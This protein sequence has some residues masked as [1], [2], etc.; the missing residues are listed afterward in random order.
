MTIKLGVLVSG[1]GSNLQAIVDAVEGGTLDAQVAVVL[2]SRPGVFALERAAAA[3]IET[4]A[5][6]PSDY[7]DPSVADSRITRELRARGVDYVVMAGYMRMLGPQVLDAFPDRV[8]NLHPALLP[9]F[10]GAHAIADAFSAGVKVT[11]VTVH[12]ANEVYDEGPIV[13]QEP[14]RVFEGDSLE[15]LEARIHEVEH[16]MYPEVLQLIA[17]GRVSIGEDRKVRIR[18]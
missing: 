12:F 3:G 7:A 9:S 2:S 11:G 14:V 5:L 8:L 13:A 1:G 18:P 17:Q 10:S 16:R 15:S 4:V 6:S